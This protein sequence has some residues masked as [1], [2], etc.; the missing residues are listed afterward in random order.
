MNILVCTAHSDDET[1][2]MGTILGYIDE[3]HNIIKIVFSSGEKSQPHF[4]EEV[5]IKR[6]VRETL[7]ISKEINLKDVVF[8]N[9]EDTKIKESF[10]K[11]AEKIIFNIL[12]QYKPEKI[13]IPSSKDPHIDHRAVNEIMLD[14]LKKIRYDK[15]LY[16]YEV[17]NLVKEENPIIYINTDKYIKRKIQIMK[18]FKSQWHFMYTLILPMY[19]RSKL[20]GFKNKCNYAEKFYKLQ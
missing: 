18:E 15:D 7:K 10:D 16:S 8:L 19:L 11:E 3:G 5:I 4:K 12:E 17:W 9:L 14:L 2:M 20:Y 13:F 1:G 6:R